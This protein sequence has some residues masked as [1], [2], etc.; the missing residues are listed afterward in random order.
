MVLRVRLTADPASVPGARRF[1]MDALVSWGHHE[2]VDVG[3]LCVSELTGNA[4]VHSAATFMEVSLD[5]LGVGIRIG[6]EDDGPTPVEAV[7][8]GTLALDLDLDSPADQPT[9]GRGLAIVSMLASDWGVEPTPRGKL[10]W[11]DLTDPDAEN[12][13]RPPTT[14][15]TEARA[16][17]PETATGPWQQFSTA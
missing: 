6:V 15:P 8:P 5:H 16:G 7:T 13:V 9:T 11:A 17:R 4:A 1:V 12:D 2:L 14:A 3:A 10:V